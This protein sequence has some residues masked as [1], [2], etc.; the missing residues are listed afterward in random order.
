MVK[1]SNKKNSLNGFTKIVINLNP[2]KE[3]SPGLF[4]QKLI[5]STPLIILS[6]IFI[7]PILLL[8]QLFIMGQTRN[9]NIKNNKWNEWGIKSNE[10]QSIKS[11][12]V[13]LEKVK[14]DLE[15]VVNPKNDIALILGE[16]YAALPK[17]I[18]FS[19]LSF[20]GERMVLKG[21]VVKWQDDYLSSVDKF[22]N[23][24]MKQEYFKSKFENVNMTESEQVKFNGIEVLKFSVKCEK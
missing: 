24:L 10:I 20:T 7:L 3:E 14:I 23:N 8:L 2:K 6:V 4:L 5:S 18:W 21:F 9:V 12:I 13:N 16:I 11:E 22:I 1:L 15:S 19:K 17:N